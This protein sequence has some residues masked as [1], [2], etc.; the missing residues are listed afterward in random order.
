MLQ[1]NYENLF[2]NSQKEKAMKKS[3]VYSSLSILAISVIVGCGGGSGGGSGGL[4]KLDD[5]AIGDLAQS[6]A[7]AIPGCTYNSPKVSMVMADESV[8]MSYKKLI[9]DVQETGKAV[10]MHKREKHALNYRI[11][12]NCPGAHGDIHVTGMHDSGSDTVTYQYN[13]YCTQDAVGDKTTLNGTMSV[14]KHGTPSAGGPIIDSTTYS[15]ASSGLTTKIEAN[16]A[17]KTKTT[18]IDN[19]V[20]KETSATATEM[21]FTGDGKTHKL[22]GL[23]VDLKNNALQVKKLTYHDPVVGAL[24]VTTSKI[25]LAGGAVAATITVTGSE[26]SSTFRT[27]DITTGKFDVKNADGDLIGSLECPDIL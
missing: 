19:L 20:V 13:D 1:Y 7:K 17:T 10:N 22:T 4:A 24:S 26:G 16:G 27:D 15:T 8:A 2:S 21:K 25:P 11:F 12:G 5:K 23:E 9:Q 14:Y 18:H 6:T 3:I